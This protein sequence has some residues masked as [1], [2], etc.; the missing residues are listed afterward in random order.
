MA[1]SNAASVITLKNRLKLSNATMRW[2]SN[3]G[4]VP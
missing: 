2:N 3:A 1:A 4:G